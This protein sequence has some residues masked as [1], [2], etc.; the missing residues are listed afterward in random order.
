MKGRLYLKKAKG[1]GFGVFCT[2]AISKEEVI[3]ACPLL[4]L[5]PEDRDR[6]L[7]SRLVDYLFS[8]N[9]EEGTIALVLGFGSMY[10]HA[11]HS[12]AAYALD[13][14]NTM[15][16]FFALEDIPAGRE[17]C[18]NYVGERGKDGKEWFEF[19]KIPYV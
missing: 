12:N 14:G 9:R 16:I 8:Y 10:N 7:A 13:E 1:K 5:P 17:I 4:V 19:R 11:T 6:L 3:D 18:I 15:M 2:R